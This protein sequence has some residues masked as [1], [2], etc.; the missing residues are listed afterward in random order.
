M[1]YETYFT[2]EIRANQSG[3]S[4][5]CHT[6]SQPNQ[7]ERPSENLVHI[8]TECVAYEDIRNRILPELSELFHQAKSNISFE[9]ISNDK[10]KLCQ[11]ILDPSSLNLS[12]HISKNE[13]LLEQLFNLSR[14]FCY[15]VHNRRMEILEKKTNTKNKS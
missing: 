8:I 12:P 15:A 14:G 6:C 11:F 4:P 2:Y 5:H 3:A 10:N 13:P 7:V 9:N 1:L